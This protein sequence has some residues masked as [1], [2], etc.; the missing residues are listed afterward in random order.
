MLNV[1]CVPEDLAVN[2]QMS[3]ELLA[4]LGGIRERILAAIIRIH[5]L[6]VIKCNNGDGGRR[7]RN[8]TGRQA[9]RGAECHA[10]RATWPCPSRTDERVFSLSLSPSLSL[11]L[12]LSFC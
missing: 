3:E 9:S 12:S 2:G 11:S 1:L 8:E 4:P 7:G 6:A 5:E 10:N